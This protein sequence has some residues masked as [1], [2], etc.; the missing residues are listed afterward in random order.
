MREETV[1]DNN[2]GMRSLTSCKHFGSYN[3]NM[4]TQTSS[5]SNRSLSFEDLGERVV[6][7]RPGLVVVKNGETP[8]IGQFFILTVCLV[9]I[10]RYASYNYLNVDFARYCHLGC[11]KL[12]RCCML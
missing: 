10:F 3:S 7:A 2:E 5:L 9:P 4:S 6:I 1:T 8:T 11:C 12:L